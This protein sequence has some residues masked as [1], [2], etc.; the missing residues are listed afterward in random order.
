MELGGSRSLDLPQ[1]GCIPI[2][3]PIHLIYSGNLESPLKSE[4]KSIFTKC[5]SE[6]NLPHQELLVALRLQTRLTDPLE[7]NRVRV[8]VARGG[9]V[10]EVRAALHPGPERVEVGYSRQP[11]PQLQSGSSS[12]ACLTGG[13]CVSARPRALD[14]PLGCQLLHLQPPVEEENDQHVVH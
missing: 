14:G 11:V 7:H 5:W 8:R 12:W 13:Q 9:R 2:D 3:F 6:E 1:T 10:K 4:T